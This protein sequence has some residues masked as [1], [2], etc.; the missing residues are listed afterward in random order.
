M[1]EGTLLFANTTV[2]SPW[3]PR[4]ADLL[5]VIAECIARYD[6]STTIELYTKDDGDPGDGLPV[7]EAVSI[8]LA[9]NGRQM[10]EWKLAPGEEGVK[11]LL[12]FRYVV[13][14]SKANHW[15]LFRLLPAVWFD[16]VTA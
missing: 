7:D 6:A 8:T 14:G 2:F 1:I 4:Q 5:R 16:A 12:R 13:T 11:Q 3:F 9:A 15:M 10:A